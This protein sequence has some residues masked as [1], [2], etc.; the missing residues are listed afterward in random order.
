[1]QAHGKTEARYGG[2]SV[3]TDNNSNKSYFIQSD[4]NG[5]SSCIS[6]KC[7]IKINRRKVAS[8]IPGLKYQQDQG[9]RRQLPF[10]ADQE[11]FHSPLSKDLQ[12]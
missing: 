2:F 7:R 5:S 9:F 12:F 1:M 8:I 4:R 10:F 3:A 6:N 11:E